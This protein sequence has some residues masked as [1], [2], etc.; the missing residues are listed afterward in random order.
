MIDVNVELELNCMWPDAI[1]INDLPIVS[2]KDD[3]NVNPFQWIL[4][5]RV[6][7]SAYPI[8]PAEE[9]VQRDAFA[10][11][12]RWVFLFQL[13]SSLNVTRLSTGGL[14]C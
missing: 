6:I 8:Q 10:R 11:R 13:F 9:L 5:D 12:V 14:S 4:V 2:H 7:I 3:V 1:V